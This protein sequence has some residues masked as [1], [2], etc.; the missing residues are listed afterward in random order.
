MNWIR[1]KKVE[2]STLTIELVK[3]SMNYTIFKK[4]APRAPWTLDPQNKWSKVEL[5]ALEMNWV[6]PTKLF[7]STF[8][9]WNG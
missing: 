9:N 4:N 3:N 7:H 1:P 5:Q 6:K 2:N 8:I